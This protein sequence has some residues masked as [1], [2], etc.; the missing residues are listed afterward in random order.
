MRDDNYSTGGQSD[1]QD[2]TGGQGGDTYTP[3]QPDQSGYDDT[4][5]GGRQAGTG[6][7][8]Q[9]DRY[10]TSGQYGGP[11]SVTTG[12]PPGYADPTRN[13]GGGGLPEDNEDNDEYGTTVGAGGGP[14]GKPSMTSRVK[15]AAE[16]MTDKIMGGK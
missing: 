5:F 15:G 16:K 9:P 7:D 3:Q 1:S 14:T 2:N 8:N 10:T 11:E 12:Q 6:I 4:T 13:T